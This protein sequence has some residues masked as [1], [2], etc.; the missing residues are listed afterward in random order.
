M[1]RLDDFR[2]FDDF[3]VSP[4]GT[5]FD[6]TDFVTTSLLKRALRAA[7]LHHVVAGAPCTFVVGGIPDGALSVFT[8]AIENLFR[9]SGID[10]NCIRSKVLPTRDPD[11]RTAGRRSQTM[12]A[13]PCRSVA[14]S[15]TIPA[16]PGKRGERRAGTVSDPRPTAA[17]SFQAPTERRRIP[18]GRRHARRRCARPAGTSLRPPPG[19]PGPV[20]PRRRADRAF[21][22]PVTR[23]ADGR[24]RCVRS[25]PSRP[26][27]HPEA[28]G[29][30]S[31]P[32]TPGWRARGR[33]EAVASTASRT[34]GASRGG[35]ARGTASSG[36]PAG[37]GSAGM[38]GIPCSPASRG[39]T[40]GCD[41][42]GA[43]GCAGKDWWGRAE[44]LARD[45]PGASA[46]STPRRP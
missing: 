5:P 43:A 3:P 13:A 26:P 2:S 22:A 19:R 30:S 1:T 28:S 21:A 23:L 24:G 17:G 4:R 8:D 36:T 29:C 44:G 7:G 20:A 45:G 35:G 15:G 31:M 41:V 9:R 14:P 33:M 42:G 18:S 40:S 39:G 38:P 34:G 25:R 27:I 11:R 12:P 10:P 37:R 46:G 16:I 32:V 6:L